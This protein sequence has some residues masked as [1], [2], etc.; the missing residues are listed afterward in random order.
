V[1]AMQSSPHG[2]TTS[3]ASVPG[4]LSGPAPQA[5][6]GPQVKERQHLILPTPSQMLQASDEAQG[7]NAGYNKPTWQLTLSR[8]SLTQTI[9]ILLYTELLEIQDP[10]NTGPAQ[11]YI[12][13]HGAK[14]S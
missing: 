10:L 11:D 3:T 5:P 13:L 4:D 8:L 1:Y 9:S 12:I 7:A 14:F 2:V 6:A